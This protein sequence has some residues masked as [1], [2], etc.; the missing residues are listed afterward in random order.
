[1]TTLPTLPLSADQCKLDVDSE[2]EAL[3]R[4][5]FPREAIDR[6]LA[7]ARPIGSFR[8]YEDFTGADG[9]TFDPDKEEAFQ[10]FFSKARVSG[11]DGSVKNAYGGS[12][13]PAIC[14]LIKYNPASVVD[15]YDSMVLGKKQEVDATTKD[16]FWAG[17]NSEEEIRRDFFKKNKDRYQVFNCSI[18]WNSKAYP[19]FVADMD[20]L[21]ID[22]ITGK[23][24]VLE[25]KHT[26][27]ENRG[28]IKSFEAGIATEDNE[29]QA[30]SYMECIDAD[31]AIILLSWGHRPADK[32][33]VR[34]ERDKSLADRILS[35]CED[36]IRYN[37]EACVRPSL[38][39]IKDPKV[40]KRA[41][42]HI[43]G[44]EAPNPTPIIFDGKFVPAFK[45]ILKKQKELEKVTE[46]RKILEKEEAAIKEAMETFQRPFVAEFGTNTWG[47]IVV[48]GESYE[49]DYKGTNAIDLEKLKRDYPDVYE[50]FRKEDIKTSDLKSARKDVYDDCRIIKDNSRKFSYRKSR[51]K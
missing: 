27:P 39:K 47:R 22:K 26:E 45:E 46:Q 9:A 40:F 49:I 11:L 12:T 44:K 33:F 37:V 31:F 5:G 6:M 51:R 14:R 15:V 13:A 29:A 16:I 38:S 34:I 2:L 35:E 3:E 25:I 42:E 20:G 32:A 21:L 7:S 4:G 24:G 18:Q 17:H 28:K 48:D 43:F 10:E 23:L 36:F 1:M 8:P 30:R 50:K 19:H 41:C